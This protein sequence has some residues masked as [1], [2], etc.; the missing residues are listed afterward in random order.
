MI[1]VAN[2]LFDWNIEAR[3]ELI[4]DELDELGKL[5]NA[6]QAIVQSVLDDYQRRMRSVNQ[7]ELAGLMASVWKLLE[8]ARRLEKLEDTI[9][10]A[11]DRKMHK[12]DEA[13]EAQVPC[14]EAVYRQ[15]M[16]E[17]RRTPQNA[18]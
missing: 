16:D 1:H 2:E 12:A 14:C 13:L 17:G 3:A 10:R 7:E 15:A 6:D 18:V 4:H 11:R 9:E 8:R 5:V